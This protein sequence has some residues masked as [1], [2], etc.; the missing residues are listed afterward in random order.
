MYP[1]RK[2]LYEEI[3]KFTNSKVIAYVTGDRPNMPIQIGSDVFDHFVDHLDTIGIT[4]RIS[5]ILYSRG[6]S[7]LAGWSIVNLIKQ[8]CKS[9][10]V[11]IPSKAHSTATLMA[12]GADAIMMTKQ[13]TLGPIDPTV[14]GPLNPQAPGGDPNARVG[15]SVESIN[16]YFEY[17]KSLGVSREE[18]L[19]KVLIDLANKINPV[20]LGNVFRTRSQIR[21]LGRRLLSSHIKD[22]NKIGKILD[23]LCSDSGSHDYTISRR[24][25]RDILGLDIAKP[26]DSQYKTFKEL[27]NDFSSEL[28]LKETFDPSTELG[29]QQNASYEH[30]RGLIESISG[31]STRFITKGVLSK[32]QIPVGPGQ[33]QEAV[34]DLRTFEGWKHH[35]A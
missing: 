11:I 35:T 31:G 18:D 9:F 27:Y 7:T 34:Q 29:T 4:N 3:E 23:F 25:A 15:I 8:F 17:A 28:K 1:D 19:A 30:V 20:V 14:N 24:E 32:R 6:G 10:D 2:P 5:L 16:G 21:M 33:F 13:A 22:D 12:L 26:N